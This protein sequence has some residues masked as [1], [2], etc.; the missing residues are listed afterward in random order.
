MQ[1]RSPG[2]ELDALPSEILS[3]V[4]SFLE[5]LD[6]LNGMRVNKVWY[7]LIKSI[8]L[9]PIAKHYLQDKLDEIKLS[10][11]CI[12]ERDDKIESNLGLLMGRRFD[13]TNVFSREIQAN[14][15]KLEMRAML[16][17]DI[18]SRIV[19]SS[20]QQLYANTNT[21]FNLFREKK[22][23]KS[24]DQKFMDLQPY[25][26]REIRENGR[27]WSLL[28]SGTGFSLSLIFAVAIL[29]M[30]LLEQKNLQTTAKQFFQSMK[31]EAQT[32][33]TYYYVPLVLLATAIFCYVAGLYNAYNH[34]DDLLPQYHEALANNNN[35]KEKNEVPVL[36]GNSNRVT[37]RKIP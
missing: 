11:K 33:L 18:Q 37:L 19:F 34:Y 4:L 13:R 1:Q 9:A 17:E 35:A 5:A 8:H 22:K 10:S 21:V 24:V 26:M 30:S 12:Q 16:E 7:D 3:H 27:Y 2:L 14:I 29:F 15:N 28:A 23:P 36:R 32:F 31:P 25:A 6:L 20:G